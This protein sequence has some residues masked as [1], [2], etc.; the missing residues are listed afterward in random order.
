[1]TARVLALLVWA[2]VAAA[3]LFWALRL[4]A[5]RP[6]V[7]AHAT[8]VA[9]E[10]A[11]GDWVRVLGGALYAAPAAAPEA[12]AGAATRLRLLGVIAP[13][14]AP[15]RQGIALIAI[16]EGPPRALRVGAV[17]VGETVVQS[18]HRRGATLGPAGG[19][20]EI[21]LE[22]PPQPPPAASAAPAPAAAPAR[23]AAGPGRPTTPAP[24]PVPR[25]PESLP[26]Q[27]PAGVVTLEDPSTP[28]D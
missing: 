2:A 23:P 3:A 22:L 14:T 16:D 18:V 4:G 20:A 27:L 19:P 13:P 9:L 10:P 12:I 17:V 8:P 26:A 5:D 7:P 25:V 11:A 21:E 24:T 15:G 28:V 6:A 1:M